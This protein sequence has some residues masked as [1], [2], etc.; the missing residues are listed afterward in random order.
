[1]PD[2]IG[3]Y[4]VVRVLG[5]G[6]FGEVF[7]ARDTGLDRRVAIK[8]LLASHDDSIPRERFLREGRSAA[9]LDHPNIVRVYDVGM[10]GDVPFI[11]QE[12]LEGET[13]QAVLARTTALDLPIAL[14]I[15]IPVAEGLHAAHAAGLVHR[16]VKPSNVYLTTN[17]NVKVIDF[18][19][20]AA[21]DRSGL[22]V[23]GSFLGTPAYASPEQLEGKRVDARSDIFSFGTVA[24]HVL[25]GRQPFE[26]DTIL[27]T[28]RQVLEKT[29]EDIADLFPGYPEMADVVRD[30]LQRDPERRPTSMADVA[31]RLRQVQA[32]LT[33]RDSEWPARTRA[34]PLIWRG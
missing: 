23:A 10:D 16:D 26:A 5:R 14:R 6:G 30:C 17:G 20:A 2:T 33:R 25:S 19:I 13:L 22:T 29:P 12:F 34:L 15:L 31:I 21:T 27:L 9:R 11:V 7:E 1:M 24:Y 32:V 28:I 4:Q 3:R 8:R 18:G